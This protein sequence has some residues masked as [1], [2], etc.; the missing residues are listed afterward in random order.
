MNDPT[1]V[2]ICQLRAVLNGVSPLV[3]RRL[4]LSSET[5]LAD[6]HKILQLAFGWSLA[7]RGTRWYYPAGVASPLS[8][9]K[10]ILT[11]EAYITSR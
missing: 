2:S 11:S 9:E 8:Y 3:W 5:T 7:Y 6:L 4:L 10:E 1:Q